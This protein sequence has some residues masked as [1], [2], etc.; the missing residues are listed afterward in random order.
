[1]N[2]GHKKKTEK[3]NEE[4]IKEVSEENEFF[5]KDCGKDC[6]SKEILIKHKDKMHKT[7]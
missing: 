5:C 2:S 4:A 1:M 3:F 6:Y 7:N